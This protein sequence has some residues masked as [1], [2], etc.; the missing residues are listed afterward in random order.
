MYPRTPISPQNPHIPP[1][2]PP[3]LSEVHVDVLPGA[4]VQL[5]AAD[6]LGKVGDAEDIMASPHLSGPPGPSHDPPRT[7]PLQKPAL[8]APL[9]SYSTSISKRLSAISSAFP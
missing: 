8:M 9:T 3:H 6:L 1:Q 7:P 5:G 2:D 4:L